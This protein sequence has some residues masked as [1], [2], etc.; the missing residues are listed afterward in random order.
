M[1]LRGLRL[2]KPADNYV[3]ESELPSLCFYCGGG[4]FHWKPHD[5]PWYKHAKWFPMCEF[6]LKKQG[7]NY[8]E[9]VCQK[10]SDLHRPGIKNPT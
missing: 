6:V 8:V 3:V 2:H 5:N 1:R 4:L 10:H 7:V 9:K